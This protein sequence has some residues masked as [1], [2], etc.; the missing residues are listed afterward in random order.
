MAALNVISNLSLVLHLP[1]ETSVTHSVAN[2][3]KATFETT[4][5]YKAHLANPSAFASSGGSGGDAAAKVVVKEEGEDAPPAVDMFG[6]G[7]N[8]RDY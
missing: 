5:V 8:G 3:F 6:G 2:T 1:T 4:E 7:D